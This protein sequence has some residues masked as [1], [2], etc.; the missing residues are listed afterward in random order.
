MGSQP[1]E[2]TNSEAEDKTSPAETAKSEEVASA[3]EPSPAEE[4]PAV[5]AE[6][7]KDKVSEGEAGGESKADKPLKAG[8]EH[9]F[10][11]HQAKIFNELLEKTA[12]EVTVEG[13]SYKHPVIIDGLL[14]LGLLVAM[15]GFTLGAVKI[16]IIHEAKHDITDRRYSDA[17]TLLNSSPM[18]GFFQMQGESPEELLD[19]AHYLDALE[20]LDKD[21]NDQDALKELDSIRPGSAFFEM[22]N[23]IKGE[24]APSS[25]IQLTGGAEHQATPAEVKAADRP[26]LPETDADSK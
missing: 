13:R 16:Y 21:K 23:N 15:A 25:P 26:L 9:K 11:P 8:E 3:S 10:H 17:I 6:A 5:G 12:P 14:A 18:P 4:T 19:Q 1:D 24:H 2:S 20:K 7:D 22:A